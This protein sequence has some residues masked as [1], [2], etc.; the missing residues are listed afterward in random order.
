MRNGILLFICFTLLLNYSFL[1]I[2][3]H[4]FFLFGGISGFMTSQKSFF[5]F[6]NVPGSLVMSAFGVLFC[7]VVSNGVFDI[8]RN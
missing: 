3:E 6:P 4:L 5:L 1:F 8:M 7:C 2:G